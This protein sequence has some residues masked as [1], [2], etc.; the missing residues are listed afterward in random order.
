MLRLLLEAAPA[1]ALRADTKGRLPLHV[2]ANW[3]SAEQLRLLLEAA[4]AAALTGD[5]AGQVPLH[6]AAEWGRTNTV[7]LLL[8]A[9]PAAAL[10]ADAARRLPLHA[11]T[12]SGCAKAVRLLVEA[13]PAAARKE[14][15][16]GLP[17]EI[18]LDKA[19]QVQD[20][21]R[22]MEI[23][24]LLLPATPPECALSALE[25]AGEAGLLLYG[26]LAACTALSP[27]QWERVPVSCPSLGAALPT[28]LARS[29][30]EGALLVG[31]LPAEARQRLRTGALC[32]VRAQREHGIELP[33]ALV[34]QVLALAAG[35]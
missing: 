3:G 27:G 6:V 30:A 2:A 7:R 5:A 35:P 23:A 26:A 33:A 10:T 8:D 17:L 28:V 9:A 34:G 18:A 20:S 14:T 19:T 24:R 22:F 15:D 11:A 13:A 16:G 29:S 32:L 4:P 31:R 1:A 25:E 12:E 21:A